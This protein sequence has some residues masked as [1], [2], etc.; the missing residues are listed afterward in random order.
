MTMV[1][2]GEQHLAEWQ[3]DGLKKSVHRKKGDY[4]LAGSDALPHDEWGG[5]QVVQFFFMHAPD[6]ILIEYF[7]ETMSNTWTL[8]VEQYAKSWETGSVYGAKSY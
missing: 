6:G 2:E 3:P 4:A 8:S 7:D 5:E 1:L